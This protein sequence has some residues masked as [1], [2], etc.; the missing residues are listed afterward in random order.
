MW[1]HRRKLKIS[2]IEK[3]TN[4]K[5]KRRMHTEKEMLLTA[6]IRQLLKIGHVMRRGTNIKYYSAEKNPRRKIPRKETKVMKNL[7]EWFGCSKN[8][9]FR[10]AASNIRIAF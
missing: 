5:V 8:Q 2:L 6:K 1:V 10:A 4:I 7:S 9:L 3:V